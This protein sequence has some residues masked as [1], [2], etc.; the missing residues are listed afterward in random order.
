MHAKTTRQMFL[1]ETAV[2]VDIVAA[3][4][5]VWRLADNVLSCYPPSFS[6]PALEF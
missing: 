1:T 6:S 4:D 2:E 3:P 5:T